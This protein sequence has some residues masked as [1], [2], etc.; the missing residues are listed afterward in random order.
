MRFPTLSAAGRFLAIKPETLST[1]IARLEHDIGHRLLH[2]SAPGRPQTPTERGHAL[3]EAIEQPN[4]RALMAQALGPVETR[5]PQTIP[6]PARDRRPDRTAPARTPGP[7]GR[8]GRPAPQ[9]DRARH[10]QD[11]PGPAGIPRPGTL[12]RRHRPTRR[13]GPRHGLSHPGPAD[14][15]RMTTE[16]W[17]DEQSWTARN[18]PGVKHQSRRHYYRLTRDGRH[19]AQIAITE[20][21]ERRRRN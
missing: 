2:R 7:V 9:T 10:H 3:L 4:V 8:P 6:G 16:R 21:R 5:P 12:R 19:A 11:T 17:E 20:R 18:K 13:P 1:Q 15:G 14:P